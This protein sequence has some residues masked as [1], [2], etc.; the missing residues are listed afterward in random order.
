MDL[1]FRFLYLLKNDAK[2]F[3][4]LFYILKIKFIY[5]QAQ[6]MASA[7]NGLLD[8]L[9]K[10]HILIFTLQGSGL[11]LVVKRAATSQ[12]RSFKGG[13]GPIQTKPKH[14][15]NI[16]TLLEAYHPERAVY[17]LGSDAEGRSY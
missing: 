7:G 10:P 6:S 12:Q 4:L 15:R 8:I 13:R 3:D 14:K 11:V 2:H 17:L 16:S 5:K 1:A 9:N